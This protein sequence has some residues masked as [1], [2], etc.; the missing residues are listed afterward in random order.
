AFSS[1]EGLGLAA[2]PFPAGGVP[3]RGCPRPRAPPPRRNAR[4]SL[5]CRA[6]HNQRDLR[7]RAAV[8]SERRTLAGLV[9]RMCSRGL[10]APEARSFRIETITDR[11]FTSEAKTQISVK[12][13]AAVGLPD[14]SR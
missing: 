14:L 9:G 7:S 10:V 3:R 5:Q 4:P 2:W 1:G 12:G 11:N 6:R 8:P 13:G